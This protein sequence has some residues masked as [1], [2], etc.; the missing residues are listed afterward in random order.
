MTRESRAPLIVA[1]VLLLLPVLYVGSYF[2]LVVR[3]PHFI[4]NPDGNWICSL[5]GYPTISGQVD[6][7]R[8]FANHCSTLYWP[9]EEF[10]RKLWPD[11]WEVRMPDRESVT[12]VSERPEALTP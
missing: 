5:D 9:L 1:I 4:P 3:K 12:G 2:A 7:Y 11:A 8:I 6:H 10:D